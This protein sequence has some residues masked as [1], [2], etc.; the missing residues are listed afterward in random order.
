M[1]L[2]CKCSAY[3]ADVDAVLTGPLGRECADCGGRV[4]TTVDVARFDAIGVSAE[5]R[6]VLAH[7]Q[8]WS[9]DEV[10]PDCGCPLLWGSDRERK[11]PNC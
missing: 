11:C 9:W 10:C 7:M 4:L 8:T 5:A 3:I 2:C 6:T 1:L